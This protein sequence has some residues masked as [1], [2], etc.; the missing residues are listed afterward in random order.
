M[1]YDFFVSQRLEIS[2]NKAKELILNEQ[3]SLNQQFFKPS[4]DVKNFALTLLKVSELSQNELLQNENLS[5]NLLEKFFVS[6]AAFKL[7]GFLEELRL[8][9]RGLNALDIGS[10]TGGFV[11][12]LLEKGAQS[13]VALDVGSNQLHAS[14]RQNERVHV[15]ENV[16]LK[17][18]ETDARFELITCDVSFTSL[19]PL[20]GKIDTLAKDAIIV[21]FKPQF[22]VGLNAKRDKK[23]VLKDEKAIL[24]A[25]ADFERACATFGWQLKANAASNL[26]GKEG[27][28]EYF[29]YFEKRL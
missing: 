6:R 23:G 20:L 5:L 7:K 27:N 13:V 8:D 15:L 16:N 28:V 17:D 4:F 1:R 19:L 14:L 12:V 10:S 29:Y 26:K 22:E 24:R 18:Y 2:K 25:R 21:L 3:I 11:Q 9:I